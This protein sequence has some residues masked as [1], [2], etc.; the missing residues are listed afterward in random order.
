[1]SVSEDIKKRLK[2]AGQRFHSNDNIAEY[3]KDGELDQLQAEVQ[4]LK[5]NK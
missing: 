5:N 3:I 1:M 2:D 4:E